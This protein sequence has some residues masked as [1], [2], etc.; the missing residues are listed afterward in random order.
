MTCLKATTTR[1]GGG[2]F[3]PTLEIQGPNR[4]QPQTQSLLRS[5]AE[6]NENTPEL[7]N[8]G[9]DGSNK[10]GEAVKK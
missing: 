2:F 7:M 6:R 8:R 1:A 4:Q 10:N 9:R 5:E 3:A